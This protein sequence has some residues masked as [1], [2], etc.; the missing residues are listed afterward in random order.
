M[1]IS[2][3]LWL[4]WQGTQFIIY[5]NTPANCIHNACNSRLSLIGS[6]YFVTLSNLNSLLSHCK[7][8][9]IKFIMWLNHL[10][11]Y[12]VLGPSRCYIYPHHWRLI[13]IDKGW[14]S[15]QGIMYKICPCVIVMFH[16]FVLVICAQEIHLKIVLSHP[17]LWIQTIC[18]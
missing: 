11:A 6:S 2:S 3:P 14:L 13:Y 18:N 10:C 16:V 12:N 4:R 9:F 15:K 8:W 5:S 1:T 7:Q 17:Q